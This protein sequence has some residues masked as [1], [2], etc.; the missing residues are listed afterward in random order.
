MGEDVKDKV[1]ISGFRSRLPHTT[2][3][4][5]KRDLYPN[6]TPGLGQNTTTNHCR[7]RVR[8]RCVRCCERAG[9]GHRCARTA[10]VLITPT[11][12]STDAGSHEIARLHV[13]LKCIIRELRMIETLMVMMRRVTTWVRPPW[14]CDFCELLKMPES[15]GRRLIH[16]LKDTLPLER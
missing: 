3:V 11:T 13:S 1:A 8:F 2:T 6:R 9:C 15:P 5:K 7:D 10:L 4:E 14:S 12:A 16:H